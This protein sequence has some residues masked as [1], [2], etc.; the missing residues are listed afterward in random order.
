MGDLVRFSRIGVEAYLQK[1]RVEVKET[2]LSKDKDKDKAHS[3]G[4]Q[5]EC[6]V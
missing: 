6:T 5:T 4:K 3:S 1:S 2:K